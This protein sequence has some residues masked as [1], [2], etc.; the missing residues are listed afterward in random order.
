MP[1]TAAPN[2]KPA[3]PARVA[4][5]GS[6]IADPAKVGAAKAKRET[7]A[8][9]NVAIIVYN[10]MELLDFAGP[11]EVFAAVD[12]G[13]AF[14]VYTVAETEKPVVSQGFVTITAQ[15]TIANCPAPDIL[16]IPGGNS[17]A[18]SRSSQMLNWVAKVSGNTEHVLTV[19]TGVFVLARAGLLDGL[20]ATTHHSAID[21]LR[22]NHPKISVKQEARVVDNGKILTAAGVSAGIDGALYMVD[23]LCGTQIAQRTA[24]YM[25]Y[26][27][28]PQKSV[29]ERAAEPGAKAAP[30]NQSLRAIVE[31]CNRKS[32]ED[33][34]KGDMLAVARGYTDDATIYFPR[35]KKVHGREAIDRLWK[36]IQGP[37]DWKLETY[38]V[39]GTSEAIYEVGK[40]SLI[41]QVDGKEVSYV[42]DYVVIWKRQKDGT[43]RTH[44]DIYN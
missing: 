8:R 33:F 10:Q 3:Q 39:G 14:K 16:V 25:E 24:D 5:Q 30:S 23:K 28:H 42:C 31:E 22:R 27:W 2:E 9:R 18:V 1:G 21:A 19:C 40:S 29:K 41:Y 35:G 26:A 32:I 12:G 38:E 7:G 44:T 37:K 20:E 15:Y 13:R 11:A 6:N 34:K 36:S 17:T 4:K 43:Y